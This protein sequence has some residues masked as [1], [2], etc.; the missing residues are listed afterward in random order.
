MVVLVRQRNVKMW[1]WGNVKMWNCGNVEL[2]K[3]E[4]VKMMS[5]VRWMGAADN[6]VFLI[7]GQLKILF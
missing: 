5:A 4:N 7:K 1:R 6:C 2:W 3:C